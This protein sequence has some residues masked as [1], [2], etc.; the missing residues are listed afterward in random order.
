MAR[1]FEAYLIVDWS[2]SAK[3]KT[4]KDSI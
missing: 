4:G 1:L 2:A 3:P